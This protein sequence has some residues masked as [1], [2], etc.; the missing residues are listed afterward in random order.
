MCLSR[1]FDYLIDCLSDNVPGFPTDTK[2]VLEKVCCDLN[3]E[4]C[5][6]DL[7]SWC[8]CVGAL[9]IEEISACK[10][11]NLVQWGKK[12]GDERLTLF[13]TEISLR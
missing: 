11:V 1:K 9:I 5:M 13:K 2:S 10:K 12:E 4:N 8:Q 3:S 6:L 7:C